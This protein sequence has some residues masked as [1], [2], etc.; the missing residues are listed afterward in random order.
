MERQG[1]KNEYKKTDLQKNANREE[2][3]EEEKY[4]RKNELI[5]IQILESTYERY[6]CFH[7]SESIVRKNWHK[8]SC[9]HE[10][11]Q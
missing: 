4:R 11:L 3:Q 2:R 10:G 8:N 9:P 6:R 5:L 7:D 1:N